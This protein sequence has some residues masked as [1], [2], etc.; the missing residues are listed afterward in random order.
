MEWGASL[1]V[2]GMSARVTQAV[3]SVIPSFTESWIWEY[4]VTFTLAILHIGNYSAIK[5]NN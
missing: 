3:L 1:V 2:Q 4:E 5:L